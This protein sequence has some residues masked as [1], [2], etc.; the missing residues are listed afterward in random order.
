[1][2]H[3]AI[4]PIE[5]QLPVV[6]NHDTKST[7]MDCTVMHPAEKVRVT[8]LRLTSF[9]PVLDVVGES[10]LEVTAWKAA[11]TEKD[12][13]GITCLFIASWPRRGTVCLASDAVH[14]PERSDDHPGI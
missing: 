9:R 1:V 11:P 13:E 14:P 3:L 4:P 2:H 12:K 5:L 10:S 6:Q 7:F 8:E